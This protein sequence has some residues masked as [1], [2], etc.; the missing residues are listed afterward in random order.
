MCPLPGLIGL[1]GSVHQPNKF[2]LYAQ[3]VFI[4]GVVSFI[5]VTGVKK[6]PKPLNLS[7]KMDFSLEQKVAALGGRK[8]PHRDRKDAHLGARRSCT[9]M[10]LS[11]P[12]MKTKSCI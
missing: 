10:K 1:K 4:R 8:A 9:K 12:L 2:C 7:P 11:T 3:F 5:L 6:P